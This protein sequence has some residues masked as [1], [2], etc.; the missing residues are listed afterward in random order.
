MPTYDY[1]CDACDHK[2]EV[3]ES[4]S[5]EPQ[6]KCPKCKKSKLRRLFGAGG[7]L[8]FKGSG[9][10]LTDYRS[11]SYKKAASADKPAGDGGSKESS[12][13]SEGKTE[14]KP[15]ASPAKSKSE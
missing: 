9:F 2:F 6:K 8:L 10:Y 11:D 4:I 15:A 3:F 5:A 13:K 7:G 1:Q 14:A 12:P